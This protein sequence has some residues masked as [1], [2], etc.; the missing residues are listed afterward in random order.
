M[1]RLRVWPSGPVR[2]QSFRNLLSKSMR[3]QRRF[4]CHSHTAFGLSLSL[5]A[6]PSKT[7]NPHRVNFV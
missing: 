6:H 1:D 2:C 4:C 3:L 7:S 5:G